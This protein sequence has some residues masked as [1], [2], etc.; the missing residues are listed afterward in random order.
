[1]V[2]RAVERVLGDKFAGREK[3]TGRWHIYAHTDEERV[4][5]V[6]VALPRL[7]TK[8]DFKKPLE[9]VVLGPDVLEVAALARELKLRPR[10]RATA[11]DTCLPRAPQSTTDG[12]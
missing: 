2:L 4:V 5:V 1:M 6:E 11:P 3:K 10:H 7:R 9:V 12:K 8:A